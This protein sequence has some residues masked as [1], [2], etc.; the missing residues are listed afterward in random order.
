MAFLSDKLQNSEDKLGAAEHCKKMLNEEVVAL[1]DK[2]EALEADTEMEKKKIAEENEKKAKELE[3]KRAEVVE[4]DKQLEAINEQLRE[5]DRRLRGNLVEKVKQHLEDLK[6]KLVHKEDLLEERRKEVDEERRAKE[7]LAQELQ[8][9]QGCM[10]ALE[11]AHK[12]LLQRLNNKQD[13]H[14]NHNDKIRLK[15]P[16]VTPCFIEGIILILLI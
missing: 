11:T 10:F 9:G 2:L 3:I 16:L 12:V 15:V 13:S 7:A 8:A 5:Y 1:K 6:N 4:R 14:R